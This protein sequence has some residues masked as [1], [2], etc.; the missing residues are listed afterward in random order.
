MMISS[1]CVII[2]DDCVKVAVQPASQSL[3][4]D[5]SAVSNS[6]MMCAVR[7]EYGRSVD[8]IGSCASVVESKVE[9]LGSEIE[10]GVPCVGSVDVGKFVGM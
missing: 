3:P 1:P 5:T 6:G 2:A 10:I 8:S 9:P 7:A 4:T